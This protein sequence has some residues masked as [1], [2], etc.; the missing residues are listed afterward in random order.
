MVRRNTLCGPAARVLFA[1]TE[2]YSSNQAFARWPRESSS[3]GG[4]MVSKVPFYRHSLDESYAEAVAGVLD[5]PFLTT[6]A[7]SRQVEQQRCGGTMN[8]AR[9]VVL[10]TDPGQRFKRGR[11]S[12]AG[13]Q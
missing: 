3:V 11:R 7:V 10:A 2:R 4:V 1:S 12:S 8:W 6:G 5:T 13:T 9:L